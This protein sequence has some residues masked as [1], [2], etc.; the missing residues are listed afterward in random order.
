MKVSR[1][2]KHVGYNK[3]LVELEMSDD[4]LVELQRRLREVVDGLRQEMKDNKDVQ[5]SILRGGE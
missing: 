5:G 3:N 1:S 4:E 2:V